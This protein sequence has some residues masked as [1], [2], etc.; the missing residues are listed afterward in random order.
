MT[1][2][3][4]FNDAFAFDEV[5]VRED[6]FRFSDARFAEM[7]LEHAAGNEDEH[8]F[9]DAAHD[10]AEWDARFGAAARA[11]GVD[12]DDLAM[13]FL[14]GDARLRFRR[15]RA[16]TRDDLNL[17]DQAMEDLLGRVA[18]DQLPD[19]REARGDVRRGGAEFEFNPFDARDSQALP[20][21]A[22]YDA[23][24]PLPLDE[25]EDEDEDAP[26]KPDDTDAEAGTGTGT[27]TASGALNVTHSSVAPSPAM[28]EL[29]AAARARE[30]NAVRPRRAGKPR[31]GTARHR[32]QTIDAET[33]L[34][35]GAYRMWLKDNSDT[36]V[37]GGRPV[38]EDAAETYLGGAPAEDAVRGDFFDALFM[39]GP[40]SGVLFRAAARDGEACAGLRAHF[41]ALF[42]A[43][44][45]PWPTCARGPRAARE[46]NKQGGG[47]RHP[48]EALA[49]EAEALALEAE[50][51]MALD[52]D[53]E[54]RGRLKHLKRSEA[55]G[56]VSSDDGGG[57]KPGPIAMGHGD[58][59][60]DVLPPLPMDDSDDDAPPPPDDF[61]ASGSDPGARRR[62]GL[63]LAD[64]LEGF[65]VDERDARSF[66]AGAASQ[67]ARSGSLRFGSDAGNPPSSIRPASSGDTAGASQYRLLESEPSASL[68][69]AARGASAGNVGSAAYN[70]MQ[71]LS[72]G[73]FTGATRVASLRG[74]CA[75]NGLRRASAARCFYQTLVLV[76]GGFL[77]V[78]Q[79]LSE[80]YGE[81]LIRPGA[82]SEG[83]KSAEEEPHRKRGADDGDDGDDDDDDD[84]DDGDDDGRESEPSEVS[85]SEPEPAPVP[86][87]R[88][89][90][91]RRG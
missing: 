91:A 43:K 42:E 71:F 10:E 24:P 70:L 22:P 48:E 59:D 63:S 64:L 26:Y 19:D 50:H 84:D 47:E 78:A 86:A 11:A 6:G 49:L 81:I 68:S 15:G 5:E 35:G 38:S 27:G 62:R 51:E 16:T 52:R 53:R 57:Y 77:D 7:A 39:R 82:R 44:R 55:F 17:P 89:K 79:D 9:F 69:L 60:D 3:V 2:D 74:L 36:R 20:D 85:E 46:P 34:G 75:E 90:R 76:S 21:E 1:R 8:A 58:D 56:D 73:V 37:L 29:Q 28:L 72:R 30:R 41:R 18:G 12:D 80:P 25:S 88:S 14:G 65:V 33:H 61:R 66:S 31:P 40:R 67:G 32:M 54:R 23:L 87:R 45:Q 83:E 4:D 13:E